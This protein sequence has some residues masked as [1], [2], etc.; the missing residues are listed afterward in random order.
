MVPAP[1]RF[2]GIGTHGNGWGRMETTQFE[3][4][5]SSGNDEGGLTGAA[6]V[7]QARIISVAVGQRRV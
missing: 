3:I 2:H 4:A 7:G 6:N 5:P 1:L